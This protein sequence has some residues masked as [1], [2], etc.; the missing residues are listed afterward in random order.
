MFSIISNL[1]QSQ[2][3]HYNSHHYFNHNNNKHSNTEFTMALHYPSFGSLVS[4]E[5]QIEYRREIYRLKKYS[6]KIWI[7]T[8]IFIQV[9]I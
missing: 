5:F 4:Y 8:L 2:D 3:Y 9:S 6:Y 1:L 7:H